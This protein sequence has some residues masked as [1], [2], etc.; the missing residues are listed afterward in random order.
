MIWFSDSHKGDAF[1]KDLRLLKDPPCSSIPDANHLEHSKTPDNRKQNGAFPG[2]LDGDVNEC[3]SAISIILK[4]E[5]HRQEEVYGKGGNQ[6]IQSI[7]KI[8]FGHKS[9]ISLPELLPCRGIEHNP[10]TSLIMGKD[11]SVHTPPRKS[12]Q[13]GAELFS[14]LHCSYSPLLCPFSEKVS[15]RNRMNMVKGKLK[16]VR[17][18][19]NDNPNSEEFPLAE[20]ESCVVS[21][22]GNGNVL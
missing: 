2:D 14:Q 19:L 9:V 3:R 21:S 7:I 15:Y 11:E 20:G 16:C 1:S 6:E 10:G 4:K 8:F 5:N 18:W 12:L 17:C 22:V 13:C